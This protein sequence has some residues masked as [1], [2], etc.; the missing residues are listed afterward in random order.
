ML[1]NCPVLYK[2]PSLIP[3]GSFILSFSLFEKRTADL[4]TA[5]PSEASQRKHARAYHSLGSHT[6]PM[7]GAR[8]APLDA[9]Q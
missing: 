9:S 3:S 5:K 6:K 1:K 8:G 4:L 7:E 2:V